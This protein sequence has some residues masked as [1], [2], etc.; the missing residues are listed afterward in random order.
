MSRKKTLRET[1]ESLEEEKVEEQRR[2]KYDNASF[3]DETLGGAFGK[4]Q[5]RGRF[6]DLSRGGRPRG[7]DRGWA[8]EPEQKRQTSGLPVSRNIREGK[9]LGKRAR[10]QKIKKYVPARRLFRRGGGF[11]SYVRIKGRMVYC[12]FSIDTT[13]TI[14]KS[15][16]A[17]LAHYATN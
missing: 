16:I 5:D 11:A 2:Q 8:A 14:G 3:A 4:P 6:G 13:V 10:N 12:D 1:L 7:K 9:P 17:A 15:T